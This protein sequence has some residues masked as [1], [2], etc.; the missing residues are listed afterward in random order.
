MNK[1]IKYT[2]A[3]LASASSVSALAQQTDPAEQAKPEMAETPSADAQSP[4]EMRKVLMTGP[5][6]KPLPP[7]ARVQFVGPDGKLLPEGA[8]IPPELL[9]TMSDRAKSGEIVVSGRRPRGSVIGDI[10]P[11]MTLTPLDIRAYGAS[12]LSELLQALEPQTQ[13]NRGRGDSK[14]VVLVNG[15]RISSFAEVARIPPEAIERTEIFPEELALKYGY[16]ADQKVVNVVTF[17]RYNATTGQVLFGAALE[18]GRETYGA[19]A[20]HLRIRGETRMSFDAEYQRSGA[21]FES[22][23]DIDRLAAAPFDVRGNVAAPLGGQIDPRLSALAGAPVTVAAVPASAA[24]GAPRLTDFVPGANLPNETDT[25]GYRTLLPATQRL[26]L[27]GTLSRTIL[28]D[29]SASVNARLEA[30]ESDSSLGLSSA[31]LL[32]RAGNPFSPFSSDVLL[33]RYIDP[34]SPLT[35]DFESW[36]FHLGTALGGQAGSWLWSFTGNYDRATT[37]TLTDAGVD[38]AA[39]QARLNARDPSVNPYADG[40]YALLAR[41]EARTTSNFAE[42]ELVF[43]GA[44]FKLPAGEVSASVKGG[45]DTRD[46]ETESTRLGVLQTGELSRDRGSVQANLDIPIANRDEGV[47]AA[48]G[49]LS[50]NFNGGVEHLSDFGTLR[51]FGYGINWSPI[52]Q[53][54]LIAS[55][56]DEDGAPSMQQLGD[57][58][59]VTP[60]VRAFDFRRGET[61]D[62]ARIDGGNPDLRADNRNVF[63]LGLNA[64]PFKTTKLWL[65][66]DYT[67]SRLKGQISFFPAATPELEAA[68]PERFTRDAGGRLLRIDNRPVN[69]ARRD[70]QELRWGANLSM[71]LGKVPPGMNI[72]EMRFGGQRR[73]LPKLP[74]GAR[75]VRLE[76][77]SAEA[78]RL[79]GM[80]S[81]LIVSAYHTWRFKDEILIR[82]GVPELDLLNGSAIGNGGG[83]PQHELQFQAAAF[84]RG[85]GARLSVNWRSGTEVD[86]APGAA[87]GNA[88]DLFFSDYSTV[89]LNLFAN[90]GERFRSP[91]MPGWMR[92]ARASISVNNLFNSRPSV[93]DRAGGTPLSYQS[94]YLDPLG[95]SVTISLRKL[96]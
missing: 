32:L 31:S 9:K 51:T 78:N 13:S 44:L 54:Q 72:G 48:I 85:L 64:S 83:V 96:F 12:D 61:V 75:V 39:V 94:G 8:P 16:R 42:A 2:F 63:R 33:Y 80:L 26:A 84:K 95:R 81:R 36:T 28:N 59:V 62:I 30:T 18:G 65:S 27:N 29:V 86:A 77:G 56:T 79:E 55:A 50:A 15:K 60:N 68:F 66:A 69:F 73:E 24:G 47:L 82:P 7:G 4:E 90:L 3:L 20:S 37:E 1:G 34:S 88:S 70:Q 92:G 17:E 67:R 43:S 23:R 52:E 76:A 6:G 53:L 38:V 74:P 49:T 14:P 19:S 25:R 71:P 87:G 89:N 45:F 58:V 93:R 21:L 91:K 5:D 41:D 11:E 10:K 40:T 46:L 57:P 35:R 22:E